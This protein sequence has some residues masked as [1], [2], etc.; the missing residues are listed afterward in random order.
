MKPSQTAALT[1]AAAALLILT[2]TLGY[3]FAAAGSSPTPEAS[4]E[5]TAA[6]RAAN[7]GDLQD[8]VAGFQELIA[9]GHHSAALYYNLARTQH[10]A[11]DLG[12][13]ILNYER[14]A[15]LDP[16]AADISANLQRA[17]KD[18]AVPEKEPASWLAAVMALGRD[19]W[20]ILGAIAFLTLAFLVAARAA[21]WTAPSQRV[22]RFIGISAV[23]AITLTVAALIVLHRTDQGRAIVIAEGAPLRVSPFEDARGV[24]S[25]PPGRTVTLVPG[26]SHENF[27]LV[28]I[29]SG[30]LGWLRPDEVQSIT[31]P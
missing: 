5:F 17:R 12:R 13:A 16:S 26:N 22:F 23:T 2:V 11:D 7:D 9:E 1:V 24:T 3:R 27:R 30:R 28:R 25:L 4:E 10:Q 31:P 29:E 14:A 18:A 21:G 8:A 20:T 6:T 19:G 15:V